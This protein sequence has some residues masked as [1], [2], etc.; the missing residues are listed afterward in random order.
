MG[1]QVCNLSNLNVEGVA[2]F[3][4]LEDHLDDMCN[5][6]GNEALSFSFLIDRDGAVLTHRNDALIGQQLSA[7]PG[8]EALRP[9]AWSSLDQ[10]DIYT[11]YLEMDGARQLF[12]LVPVAGTGYL[13]ASCF[14][15]E[16]LDQKLD[17]LNRT[18]ALTLTAMA[19]LVLAVIFQFSRS[20]TRDVSALAE[21]ILNGSWE[22]QGGQEEGGYTGN[23]LE[24]I[25]SSYHLL[26]RKFQSAM[27]S[28]RQSAQREKRL[29]LSALESQINSH[30]LYNTL[31]SINWMAIEGE[32]YEISE[33]ISRLALILRYSISANARVVPFSKEL[34]WLEGHLYIQRRRFNGSFSYDLSI[35]HETIDFPVRKL[36]LQPFIE[37][38]VLHG[39]RALDRPGL[40][41]LSASSTAPPST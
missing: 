40:I 13:L 38:A 1:E 8:L 19:L 15:Y 30:F 22:D 37:N 29:E 31:D 9:Q 39:V 33:M 28:V 23:E 14:G 11:A 6:H 10:G 34:S 32:N 41:A 12:T 5:L 16:A 35:G 36:I 26:L 3:A 21:Q 4:I 27:D 20:I 18:L 7:L 25:V 24:I 2:I 17:G